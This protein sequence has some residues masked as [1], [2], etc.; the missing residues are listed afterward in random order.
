MSHDPTSF[1]GLKHYVQGDIMVLVCQ[2]VLL[3]H[4][5]KGSCDFVSRSSVK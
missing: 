2:V 3:D 1:G 5:I 4:V